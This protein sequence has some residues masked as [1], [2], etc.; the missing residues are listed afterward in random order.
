MTVLVVDDDFGTRETFLT[1]LLSEGFDIQTVESGTRALEMIDTIDCDFL[2]IDLQLPDMFGLELA[3]SLK[4]RTNAP[5]LIVSGFLTVETTVAAMRLGARDVL[6]KPVDIDLIIR[7]LR[8]YD[9]E[10]RARPGHGAAT[11]GQKWD[12]QPQSGLAIRWA[13]LILKGTT[14][15]TDLRTIHDWARHVGSSYSTL[16]ETCR[17]IGIR[18]HAARDFL[19]TLR[20]FVQSR[21]WPHSPSLL[22]DVA[23][24]RTLRHLLD[25]AGPSFQASND[26]TTRDFVSDQKFISTTNPGVVALLTLLERQKHR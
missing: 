5:F 6:E 11:P 1:A 8:D 18:P 21:N 3:R 17:L 25:G 16:C 23:D 20:A 4:E 2:I 13:T 7:R 22:L 10:L 9:E 24:R 14:A 12:G 15:D 19:R 26:R